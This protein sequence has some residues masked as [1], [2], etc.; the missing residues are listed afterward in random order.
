MGEDLEGRLADAVRRR[1]GDVSGIGVLRRLTGGANQESFAFEARTR[2]E[3]RPLI[4]RRASGALP[5]QAGMSQVPLE[6]EARALELAVAGGVPAPKVEFTLEPQD[7]L[8]SGYVMQRI[9][10]ETIPRKILREDAYASGRSRL[11]RQCGQALAKIHALDPAALPELQ[12]YSGEN[13]VARNAAQIVRWDPP[14]PVLELALRWLMNHLPEESEPRIVH[15]DFRNGNLIVGP[16]GLRAVLDW[17]LVHLGDP[18]EDI[19]WI[20][21]NCWRFGEIDKKVG[22]FGTLEELSEGYESA[23]GAKIDPERVHWWEVLASAKWAMGCMMMY[24]AYASGADR[25]IERAAI[26]RR[27]SENEIDLLNLLAPRG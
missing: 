7:G 19:G 1:M 5:D 6:L 24:E 27:L 16:D 8:G 20:C 22:G 18:M 11:A 9:E 25:S 3:V 14:H 2:D 17:E 12:L 26:G 23:G 13:Q 4:L 15:G 21:A 10:G